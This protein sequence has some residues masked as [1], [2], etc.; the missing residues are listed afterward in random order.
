MRIAIVGAGSVGRAI[1][2]ELLRHAHQITLLDKDPD[3]IRVSE[4]P[5]ADWALSDA[6]SPSALE[7]AGLRECDALV[8]AT[9]DDK[10]N[11]VVSLLAKSEF[12][13]PKVVARVNDPINEWLFTKDWGVD[14]PTSTPRVMAALVEEA[15]SSGSAVRLFAFDS[16]NI[17]VYTLA[18]PPTS[19]FVNADPKDLTWPEGVTVETIIR[20]GRPLPRREV[21]LLRAG[22][23]LLVVADQEHLAGVDELEAMVES[24]PREAPGA[25]HVETPR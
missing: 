14:I 17:G 10:T 6:C 7:D 13:V 23:E 11:L 20:E 16:T 24:V 1:T 25:A 19:E 9:G 5:E 4:I 8:A 12:A 2:L 3:A 22:D 15:V 18:I 21:N